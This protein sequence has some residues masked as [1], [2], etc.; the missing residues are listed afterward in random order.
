MRRA[1][2]AQPV[3]AGRRERVE[4]TKSTTSMHFERADEDSSEEELA[5]PPEEIKGARVDYPSLC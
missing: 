3:F 1:R 5:F 2:L 4:T